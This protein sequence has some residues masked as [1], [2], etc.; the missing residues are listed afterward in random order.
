VNY[1]AGSVQ[2]LD[3]SLQA[4][5]VP[6][7]ISVEDNAVFGQQNRRF[8]GVNVMHQFSDNFTLG[9]TLLN[10]N[11]RPLTQKSNYGTEAVNN[12]IFGFNTNLTTSLPFL[13][14][15]ANY[16]PNV[17]TAVPSMLSLRGE[18]AFLAPGAP[19]NADFRGETTT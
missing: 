1:T 2:L 7:E 8:T 17:K 13:T 9:G 12:T 11:E 3:P 16:L 15:W 4:S 18:V 19:R 5:N 14:R 10:L 6:I